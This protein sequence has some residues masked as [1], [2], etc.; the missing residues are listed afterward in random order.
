M[1][2]CFGRIIPAIFYGW[3]SSLT[4]VLGLFL[5]ISESYYDE[6]MITKVF[7][8]VYMYMYAHIIMI[9]YSDVYHGLIMI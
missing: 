5:K 3:V 4:C 7:L 8:Y 6:V 2:W 1:C 9:K